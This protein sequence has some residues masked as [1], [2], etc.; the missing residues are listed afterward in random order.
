MICVYFTIPPH[1]HK[2][3]E[4]VGCISELGQCA[5]GGVLLPPIPAGSLGVCNRR[6]V[7]DPPASVFL[8][9]FVLSRVYDPAVTA[10]SPSGLGKRSS[11]LSV[12]SDGGRN[13]SAFVHENKAGYNSENAL[14]KSKALRCISLSI[15]SISS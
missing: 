8:L 4:S 15:R 10:T 5:G 6:R 7:C 13:A 14:S 11:W 1:I 3:I 12:R 9:A 2:L